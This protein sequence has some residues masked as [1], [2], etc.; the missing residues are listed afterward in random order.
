MRDFVSRQTAEGATVS[1]SNAATYATFQTDPVG[2]A[3]VRDIGDTQ[4]VKSLIEETATRIMRC[5]SVFGLMNTSQ[6]AGFVGIVPTCMESA[7]AYFDSSS[8]F[9][10]PLCCCRQLFNGRSV[11]YMHAAD[12]NIHH[13]LKANSPLKPRMSDMRP[14]P[15]DGQ[16]EMYFSP[17][18]LIAGGSAMV[19]LHVRLGYGTNRTFLQCV[20]AASFLVVHMNDSTAAA[21]PWHP[22]QLL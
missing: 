22:H 19:S 13:P 12:L 17:P 4:I 9:Q 8:V 2:L 18:S 3:E 10:I 16:F 6:V 11:Y 15:C 21:R 7:R 20:T 5:S 14:I 1:S